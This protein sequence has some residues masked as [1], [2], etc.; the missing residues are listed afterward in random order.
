VLWNSRGAI[1]LK[2]RAEPAELAEGVLWNSRRGIIWRGEEG[3]EGVLWNSRRG[4]IWRG[5]ERAEEFS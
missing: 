3:A 5:R 1:F 2:S 4:I